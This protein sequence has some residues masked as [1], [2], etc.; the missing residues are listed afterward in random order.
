[1]KELFVRTENFLMDC[2]KESPHFQNN[3]NEYAYRL[4]HSYRV[5]N[6]GKKIAQQ[7]GFDVPAM[8]VACLLHDVSYG[9]SME[10][11]EQWRNHGRRA[12]VISR[13]FVASLGFDQNTIENICYGIAIHVVMR[14][15][16]KGRGH[17]LP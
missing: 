15:I 6:I 17:L 7:E 9:E 3:P 11:N 2:L 16:L 13:P 8:V 10:T 14:R 1:M 12:A 4:E 5:A